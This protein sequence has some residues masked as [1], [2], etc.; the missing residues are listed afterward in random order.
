MFA[1]LSSVH[2]FRWNLRLDRCQIDAELFCY[3]RYCTDLNI[4][5]LPAYVY[6]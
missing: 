4:K 6:L 3:K 5:S 1:M 2:S